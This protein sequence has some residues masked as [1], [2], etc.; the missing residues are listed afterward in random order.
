[1]ALVHIISVFSQYLDFLISSLNGRSTYVCVLNAN[2]EWWR[3]KW[4]SLVSVRLYGDQ[5]TGF[6]ARVCRG[7]VQWLQWYGGCQWSYGGYFIVWIELVYYH[8]YAVNNSA[9]HR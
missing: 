2:A 8:F 9:L 3:A 4:H 6:F 1:M 7:P 5:Q